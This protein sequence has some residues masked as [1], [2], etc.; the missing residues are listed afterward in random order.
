L[1]RIDGRVES[2]DP[3]RGSFQL[4]DSRDRLVVV[5]VPFNAP[6]PLIENFNRLREGDL[7]EVEGRRVGPRFELESFLSTRF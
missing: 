4:R 1:E 7:V 6:Q 2:I 3:R 5:S